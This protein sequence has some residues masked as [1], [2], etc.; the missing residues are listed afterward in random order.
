MRH[1][2]RLGYDIVDVFTDRPFAGNQLAVVR[3][4]DDLTT[5]Q[6]QALAQEFGFSESTFPAS[7]VTEG[8]AYATRIFT[9]AAE[10]PFAGHPTLGTAWVLRAHGLLTAD[11]VTELPAEKICISDGLVITLAS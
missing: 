4:A 7:S 3:G 11:E 6:C 2:Q 8:S 10:I 1:Q 5:A 9:P